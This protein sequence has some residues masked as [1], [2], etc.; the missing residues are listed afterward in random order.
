MRTKQLILHDLR[1]ARENR[2]LAYGVYQQKDDVVDGIE[3]ELL[4]AME[5]DGITQVK[6]G[7]LT[8][9]IGRSIVP[10]AKDWPAAYRYIH[11]HKAF[12]LLER[13]VHLTAWREEVEGGKAIPGIEPFERVKLTVKIGD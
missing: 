8:A 13:R 9:S 6:G 10:M 2:D 4:A 12:H 3:Q 5:A 1:V 11:R 7:G